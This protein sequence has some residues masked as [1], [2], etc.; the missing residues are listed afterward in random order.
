MM[1]QSGCRSIN[2][3]VLHDNKV[4]CSDESNF[5][6]YNN[7]LSQYLQSFLLEFASEHLYLTA[8]HPAKVMVWGRMFAVGVVLLD[9]MEGN[10]NTAK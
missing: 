9:I 5:C 8:R 7:Q 2:P 6:T 1:H 3:G 4:I 10:T